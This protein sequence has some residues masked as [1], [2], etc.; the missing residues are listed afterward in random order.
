MVRQI[1]W[2][3]VFGSDM[4][5]TSGVVP[6]R[7]EHANTAIR[8]INVKINDS[9]EKMYGITRASLPSLT[10]GLFRLICIFMVVAQRWHHA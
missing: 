5:D 2:F 7:T 9:P 10:N 4:S 6:I 1:I 8:G 3:Y